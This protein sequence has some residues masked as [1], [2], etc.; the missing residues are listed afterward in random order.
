MGLIREP[1]GVDFIISGGPLTPEG[2]AEVSAWIRKDRTAK[3]KAKES[4]RNVKSRVLALPHAER[5]ELV[6]TLLRNLADDDLN[7]T[8]RDSIRSAIHQFCESLSKV[9]KRSS[10]VSSRLSNSRGSSAT[11]RKTPRRTKSART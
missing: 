3:A 2:A 9:R 11:K 8:T 6:Q 5:A 10:A 7:E 4:L 1:E